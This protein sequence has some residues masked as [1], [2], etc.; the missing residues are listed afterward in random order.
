VAL[1]NVGTVH[2]V[3]ASLSLATGAFQLI[4]TRRDALHRRVGYTYVVAMLVNNI[5][6]LTIHEFSGGFNVFH[7][8]AIY[9]LISISLAVRPMLVNPR[10]YQWKRIHYM[11]VAWSY[12]GLSAAAVTEGLLR[13]AHTSWQVATFAGS[14]PVIAIGALLITRFRPAL[15]PVRKAEVA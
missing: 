15:R 1:S 9:S 3:A 5:T 10:P 4:R 7:A 14:I 12:A 6:A 2:M 8:F 11:W 13:V